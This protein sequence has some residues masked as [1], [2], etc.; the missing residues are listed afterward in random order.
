MRLLFISPNP[1]SIGR[2]GGATI[3]YNYLKQLSIH[4]EVDLVTFQRSDEA[5]PAEISDLLN[6]VVIFN[7]P[8]AR[9]TA[10]NY[11]KG[12]FL[13][14]PVAV[15]HYA[16]AEIQKEVAD[17]MTHESYDVV[18]CQMTST[19]QFVPR[20]IPCASVIMVE[21][22]QSVKYR[23]TP[24]W[25]QHVLGKA[26]TKVEIGRIEKYERRVWK[27]FDRIV[28]L[29]PLDMA[30]CQKLYPHAQF[31]WLA[32]GVDADYFAPRAD[33]IREEDKIIF[34]GTMNHPPNVA[35]IINFCDEI[36]P[37]IIA[38][39]P[40]AHLWIVGS[41]PT[42][43][44]QALAKRDP[45]IHVT[46]FVKDMR[47]YLLSATVSVCTVRLT[48]GAQTKVLEAMACGVPVV[49]ISQANI[50]IGATPGKHLL[51]ADTPTNFAASV[52][53]VLDDPIYRQTLST[54]SRQFIETER[55][56]PVITAK[57]EQLLQGLVNATPTL[58][59]NAVV[60][61]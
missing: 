32:Y 37:L 26:L 38:Q 60:N 39:R 47:D 16:S 54:Q 31:N 13:G 25:P 50:G 4:H 28:M 57:L 7:D 33:V 41:K 29:N 6:R 36:F 12:L 42:P 22:P 59:L 53:K 46:G 8:D 61:G 17:L 11:A 10:L 24:P 43:E 56:W 34:S 19:T 27:E 45:R 14:W 44:V 9:T 21:D 49:A 15:S 30:E 55:S 40:S 35:A 52:L 1:P 58:K 20:P 48:Y 3:L 51:I 18:I 2:A 23:D 5:V